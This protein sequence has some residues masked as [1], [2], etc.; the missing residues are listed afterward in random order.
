MDPK[1][2]EEQLGMMRKETLVEYCEDL[3]AGAM[4]RVFSDQDLKNQGGRPPKKAAAPFAVKM[5]SPISG[6]A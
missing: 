2:T 1:L 3:R 6:G 5:I 4:P